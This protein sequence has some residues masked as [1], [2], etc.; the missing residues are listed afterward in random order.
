MGDNAGGFLR[1][2]LLPERIRQIEERLQHMK[3]QHVLQMKENSHRRPEKHHQSS[4]PSSDAC[5][6]YKRRK[7]VR[8]SIW[9]LALE[10]NGNDDDSLTTANILSLSGTVPLQSGVTCTCGSSN[11]VAT[12]N[13]TGCID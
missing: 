9:N 7:S 5:N 12:G 10:K 11:I 4:S 13:V 1:G 8:K 6:P 2:V 3:E